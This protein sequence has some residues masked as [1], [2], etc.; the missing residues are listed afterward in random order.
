[1][2]KTAKMHQLTLYSWLL[3][4]SLLSIFQY[5]A[6]A[7]PTSTITSFQ[8][9]PNLVNIT[10]NSNVGST[11]A[12][13]LLWR[14]WLLTPIVGACAGLAAGVLMRLLYLVE[15]LAWGHAAS[16][17]FLQAV[18]SATPSVSLLAAELAEHGRAR[19]D[20]GDALPPGKANRAK[21]AAAAKSKKK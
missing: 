6:V 12:R 9:F 8:Q 5:A 20:G 3:S 15:A 11:D 14:F 7:L 18:Q 19:R 1:M 4:L 16:Q 13:A 2:Q 17:S 10:T 21:L